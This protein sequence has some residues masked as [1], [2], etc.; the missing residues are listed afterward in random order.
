MVMSE[1]A[2][3]IKHGAIFGL[4]MLVGWIG[5]LFVAAHLLRDAP[6]AVDVADCLECATT[7]YVPCSAAPKNCPLCS[8]ACCGPEAGRDCCCTHADVCTCV[9]P[10]PTRGG[11]R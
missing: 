4:G 10:P 6:A 8:A 9:P 2:V 1:A 5:T 7:G 11:D 3:P